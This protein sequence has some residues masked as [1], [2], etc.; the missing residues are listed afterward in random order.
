MMMADLVIALTQGGTSN[1]STSTIIYYMYRKAFYI[2]NYGS[3][4]AAAVLAFILAFGLILA[5]FI[6]E[7]KKVHYS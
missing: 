5:S 6:F 3:A 1:S 4:Y 2:Y 7:K